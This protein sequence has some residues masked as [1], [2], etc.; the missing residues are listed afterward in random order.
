MLSDFS[1]RIAD[2]ERLQ[3]L[4]ATGMSDGPVPEEIHR[5]LRLASGSLRAPAAAFLLLG[6]K[7]FM[8]RGTLGLPDS[9]SGLAEWPLDWPSLLETAFGVTGAVTPAAAKT[10]TSQGG[11]PTDLL[12]AFLGAPVED[13]EGRIL[14]LLALWDGVPRQW[15]AAEAETL[16]DFAATL[17]DAL[18]GHPAGRGHDAALR[19]PG[20]SEEAL[21]IFRN[22]IDS[23]LKTLDTPILVFNREGKTVFANAAAATL[24]G[25]RETGELMDSKPEDISTRLELLDEFLRPYPE[26]RLPSRRALRGEAVTGELVCLRIKA[27]GETKWTFVKATPLFDAQ[28]KVRLAITVNQD[29][30]GIKTAE[31]EL[32]RSRDELYV[33]LRTMESACTAQDTKGNLVYAND[34]AAR[35]LAFP[36]AESLMQTDPRRIMERF[37]VLD[38]DLR[39]LSLEE[40]PGRLALLGRSVSARILCYRIKATGEERWSLVNATPVFDD[41]GKVRLVINVFNDITA[42]KQAQTEIQKSRNQLEIVLSGVDDAIFVTELGDGGRLVYANGA[43]ARILEYGSVEELLKDGAASLSSRAVLMDEAGGMVPA[44]RRPG[45]VAAQG[46]HFPPTMFRFRLKQSGTERWVVVK[47]TPIFSA[48]GKVEMVVSIAQDMTEVRRAQESVA[49]HVRYLEGMNRISVAIERTLDVESA[50]PAA[51]ARLLDVF[52]CERAWL[53]NLSDSE[54]SVF[55]VPFSADHPRRAA[56]AASAGIETIPAE[57]GFGAIA[58]A[59]KATDDPLVFGRDLPLPNAG[60]WRDALGVGS[61]KVITVRPQLGRPWILCLLRSPEAAPWKGDDFTMFKDIA[62]LISNALGSV[63]LYRDVRRSEEKYRTLFERSLD[64]IFRCGPDGAMMDANPALVSLLGYADRGQLVGTMQPRL[65]PAGGDLHGISDGGDTFSVELPRRDGTPVWVE[66]NAQPILRAGG[67]I[68]YFEGIVRNINDRKRAEEALKASEEKLR[69]SQKMEAVGRLAGGVA[70]DFNN[71][72]TAINGFSDLLLMTFPKDDARRNHL[73]EIRKAG[74]RAAALTSQLLSF[75]RKQVLAPR[76]LDVNLVVSGMET[77]LRRLIGENIEFKSR[78]DPNVP[79]VVADP[80]QLEQVILNLV[81]NARDA[82]PGGGELRLI[83]GSRTFKEDDHGAAF[84]EVPPG[85]YA[86][87]SVV[88]TGTGMD[89][90][91]KSRLFEPFFTT[92]SKD[93]GTG[94]GLSTVYGAIKQANGS[95]TVESEPDKGTVFSIYLPAASKLERPERTRLRERALRSLGGTE[96]ILLVE[97]ED[98]VR[99]LVRDVLE[100]GGYK[101]LEAPGGEQALELVEKQ[102]KGVHIHLLLTDVVMGGISGRVLAEKLREAR[103]DTKV[104]FMS[105]YTEDAII[106]HGVYTA[107]ASFIGKPFSP[108]A[109]AAKVREVLDGSAEKDAAAGKAAAQASEKGAATGTQ[110]A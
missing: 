11:F 108:A 4:A 95:I 22:E 72:L 63:I 105:G 30:T 19:G 92:K 110:S 104:L 93:K 49:D 81:L 54:D 91:T 55:R 60:Y 1:I 102:A 28:G 29:V 40:I 10:G 20:R 67:G 7:G 38:E 17:R 37:E 45:R 39:P 16:R 82:M 59:C 41:E 68:A 64:G 107:Q 74:G 2:P 50:L 100:V 15:T 97:D 13:G 90:E 51:M 21:S 53:V 34:A 83:T 98:A 73:E 35:I 84:P 3:A 89:E 62:S 24:L 78:L 106:R 71:L 36:D 14:G 85:Q 57:A 96:T 23:I 8:P 65:L 18:A 25:Y 79:K 66:V 101:V 103:P 31:M 6:G 56:Q 61:A 9:I 43:A 46:K 109:I 58:L 87:L 94:L 69:Q 86:L 44:E 12:P 52:D 26:D 48:D 33:M 42:M 77:M 80:N 5:L 76:V 32:Q 27:T 88:D 75:S 47:S 70:H 99:R